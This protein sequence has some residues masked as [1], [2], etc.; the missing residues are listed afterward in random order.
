MSAAGSGAEQAELAWNHTGLPPGAEQDAVVRGITGE[1]AG[2]GFVVAQ[3][4]RVVN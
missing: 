1:I 2:R 4:D 3:L